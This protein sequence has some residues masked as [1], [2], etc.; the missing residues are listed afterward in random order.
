MLLADADETSTD[1]KPQEDVVTASSNKIVSEETNYVSPL[2][3]T[4]K[5]KAKDNCVGP[6]GIYHALHRYSNFNI[7]LN[8]FAQCLQA[9]T[10]MATGIKDEERRKKILRGFEITRLPAKIY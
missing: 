7:S 8:V 4:S 2:N 9:L 6:Y 3:V 5:D 10:L 1:D